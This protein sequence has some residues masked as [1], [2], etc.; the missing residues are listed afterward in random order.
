M[1]GR[2]K[3]VDDTFM[4]KIFCRGIMSSKSNKDTNVTRQENTAKQE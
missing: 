1:Y 3:R 2:M 4:T